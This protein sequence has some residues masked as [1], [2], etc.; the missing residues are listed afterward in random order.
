MFIGFFMSVTFVPIVFLCNVA[1]YL[2]SKDIDRLWNT[3]MISSASLIMILNESVFSFKS[4]DKQ[5][6]FIMLIIRINFGG[7]LS[8]CFRKLYPSRD[9]KIRILHLIKID[10]QRFNIH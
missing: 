9:N 4:I 1:F 8:T 3:K 6:I 5:I 10:L 7:F 2:F